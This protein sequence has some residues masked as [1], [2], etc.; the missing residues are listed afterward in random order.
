MIPLQGAQVQSLVLNSS[1]TPKQQQNPW[2]YCFNWENFSNDNKHTR[3]KV[4]LEHLPGQGGRILGVQ[5]CFYF[6]T[7]VF[8]LRIQNFLKKNLCVSLVKCKYWNLFSLLNLSRTGP[9]IL[10]SLEETGIP[11]QC[12]GMKRLYT[13]KYLKGGRR[14][15]SSAALKMG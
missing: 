2:M 5:F 7:F 14:D 11:N 3:G 8:R 1:P 15:N 12:P 13:E 10:I 4:I 9:F 6:V